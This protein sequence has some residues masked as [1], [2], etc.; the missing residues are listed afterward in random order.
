MAAKTQV[1][2]FC[3]ASLRLR[4]FVLM[5]MLSGSQVAATTLAKK[6]DE[7]NQRAFQ[8]LLRLELIDMKEEIEIK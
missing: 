6:A 8:L 5:F 3:S 4:P 2:P 7:R 1:L